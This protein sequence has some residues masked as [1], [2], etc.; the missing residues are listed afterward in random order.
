MRAAEGNAQV[1]SA[2]AGIVVLSMALAVIQKAPP[3][4][5]GEVLTQKWA[6]C[7]ASRNPM[8]GRAPA[9]PESVPAGLP[10]SDGT[11]HIDSVIAPDGTAH[12]T[13]QESDCV[14]VTGEPAPGRT[15]WLVSRIEPRPA[16][17]SSPTGCSSPS[18]RSATPSPA[19]TR[20]VTAG[21]F[22]RAIGL[23][24]CAHGRQR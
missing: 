21:V 1:V 3:G 14:T 23:G 17:R 24:S 13:S 18:P 19:S 10:A 11:A 16:R 5:P 8:A 22:G 9:H 12:V 2:F 20:C 7:P 6:S 4:H 15:L